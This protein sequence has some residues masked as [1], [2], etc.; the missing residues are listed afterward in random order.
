MSSQVRVRL[1]TALSRVLLCASRRSN[2]SFVHCSPVV[3]RALHWHDKSSS[4][5]VHLLWYVSFGDLEPAD[6]DDGCDALG[7]FF[8][9]PV[10]AS[11]DTKAGSG[12][13][14]HSSWLLPTE[15]AI[16]GS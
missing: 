15:L 2:S 10:R 1:R 14:S 6:L 16:A 12:T 5:A 4:A 13:E 3:L 8:V 11:L 9:S 7:S